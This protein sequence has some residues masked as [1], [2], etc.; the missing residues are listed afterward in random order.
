MASEAICTFPL[1]ETTDKLAAY[2]LQGG[3]ELRSSRCA[4]TAET[5]SV[6][7][8]TDMG[9]TKRIGTD[10]GG[11]RQ[12]KAESRETEVSGLLP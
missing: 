8:L 9:E 10:T 6:R 4:G 1:R 12:E 3:D 11:E 2:E 7:L 5:R